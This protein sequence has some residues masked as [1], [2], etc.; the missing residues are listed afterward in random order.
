METMPVADAYS[1][2]DFS[3]NIVLECS[4]GLACVVPKNMAMKCE[5][6][7]K[8]MNQEESEVKVPLSEITSD[9][10]QRIY[11]YLAEYWHQWPPASIEKIDRPLRQDLKT[12]LTD[13]DEDYYNN[14][15]LQDGDINKNT[16]IFLVLKASQYLDC[17]PLMTF[18]SAA[19]AN[20]VRNVKGEDDF[21]K[22]FGVSEPFTDKEKQKLY[23]DYEYRNNDKKAEK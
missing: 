2:I 17:T 5:V 3:A 13:F 15:L 19:L 14:Q 4:D 21:Y 1:K 11:V 23:E 10:V 22:Q 9:T 7:K 20:I 6:L 12:F 18:A 8:L 16:N